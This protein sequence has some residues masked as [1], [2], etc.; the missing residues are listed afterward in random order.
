MGLDTLCS[1]QNDTLLGF[2]SQRQS[3][4]VKMKRKYRQRNGQQLHNVYSLMINIPKTIRVH[5]NHRDHNGTSI[6]DV[7][8]EC[9]DC[10]QRLV[11]QACAPV[12]RT[13]FVHQSC[14]A[15]CVTEL[16]HRAP[17]KRLSLQ[18]LTPFLLA[19]ARLHAVAPFFLQPVYL[20]LAG[21]SSVSS[22]LPALHVQH[23]E[24]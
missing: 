13:D 8:F 7:Q 18:S 5:R 22:T 14:A 6:E 15:I 17:P 4:Q 2:R 9:K 11:H 1:T 20:C 12:L 16:V 10:S 21:T 23:D 19:P 3:Q 24:C